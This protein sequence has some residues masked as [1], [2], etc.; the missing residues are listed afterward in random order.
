MFLTRLLLA[1]QYN[2]YQWICIYYLIARFTLIL[3]LIEQILEDY[4]LMV[5]SIIRCAMKSNVDED[6][7]IK[8]VM[9]ETEMKP[10][11]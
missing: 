2:Y 8:F 1:K 11:S 5:Y 6:P 7:T 10:H 4:S 9:G 3:R